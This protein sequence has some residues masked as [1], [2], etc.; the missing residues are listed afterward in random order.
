MNTEIRVLLSE[1]V[2]SL[3]HLYGDKLW[4][5]VLYGSYAR[6]AATDQSDIDVMIVLDDDISFGKEIRRMN[7]LSTDIL[8]EHGELISLYPVSKQRY[9]Q[10]ETPLLINVHKEGVSLWLK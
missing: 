5:V 9:E 10:A 8:L 3:S 7:E 2:D 6:N 1:F 4:D